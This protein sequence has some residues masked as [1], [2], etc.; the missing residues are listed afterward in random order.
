MIL[1]SPE[2]PGASWPHLFKPAPSGH[3]SRVSA[4]SED[5][6]SLPLLALTLL[7][8]KVAAGSP[9][10]LGGSQCLGKAWHSP[11]KGAWEGSTLGWG[12][13][14]SLLHAMY[15]GCWEPGSDPRGPWPPLTAGRLIYMCSLPW[16]LRCSADYHD[17]QAQWMSG[18]F[19]ERIPNT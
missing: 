15:C 19:A 10:P 8:W 17:W 6:P 7:W 18:G 14:G 5:A 9:Y 16:A 4:I 13:K 11:G 1:V 12:Y 2:P 3:D